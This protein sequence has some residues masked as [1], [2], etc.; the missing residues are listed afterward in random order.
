MLA[1]A[2]ALAAG[3]YGRMHPARLSTL[4]D[5]VD[6]LTGAVMKV[7]RVVGCVVGCVLGPV[8]WAM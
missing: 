4:L 2:D 5:L 8:W 6:A 1:E 7:G 3:H